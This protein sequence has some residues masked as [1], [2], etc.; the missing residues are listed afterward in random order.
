MNKKYLLLFIVFILAM[1]SVSA[2]NFDNHDFDGY[3][4]MDV[5]SGATF[6]K[7]INETNEEGIKLI[8][9]S[10]MNNDL[11]VMYMESPTFSEN[12]SAWFYQSFFESICP[13]LDKCYESQE[14]NLTILEPK[15]I[16]DEHLPMVGVSS[17]NEIVIIMG[18]DLDLIKEMGESVDFN[19]E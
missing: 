3:F 19:V 9:A 13:D 4:T 12:S 2:A 16:N 6:Q 18:K 17:G 5:P 14:G 8:M 15:K 10:Y 1:G 11:A 7:D